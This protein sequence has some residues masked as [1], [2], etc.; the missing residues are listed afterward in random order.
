LSNPKYKHI[1]DEQIM[2][3]NYQIIS[4]DKD[5]ISNFIRYVHWQSYT[6]GLNQIWLLVK[7]KNDFFFKP[8]Y[9]LMTCKNLGSNYGE[10]NPFSLKYG[11][12]GGFPPPKKKY[13]IEIMG[14]FFV[15]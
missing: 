13:L 4:Q 2:N 3:F 9:V 5:F 6:K 14:P 8:Y 7:E 10:F 15:T 12:F 1:V 11:K